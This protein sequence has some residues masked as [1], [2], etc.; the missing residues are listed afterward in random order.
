MLRA[1]LVPI[2]FVFVALRLTPGVAAEPQTAGRG[3]VSSILRT[4]AI[5][6]WDL[7][8]TRNF[9]IYTTAGS[10]AAAGLAADC[11]RLRTQLQEA[12]CDGARAAWNPKCD[13]V[14]HATVAEYVR[15]LGPGSEHSSGC[16]SLDKNSGRIVR[17][18]IDLR[19]DA[20]D[21]RTASLPHELTHVVVADQF[22]VQQ[23][24]RWADEGMAILAEPPSKRRRRYAALQTAL[25]RGHLLRPDEVLTLTA[26][27]GAGRIDA[28]YGESAL[29][30]AE[31][32]ARKSPAQF[33]RFVQRAMEVG[34]AR[35]LAE[36]YGIASVAQ[37]EPLWRSQ[38][39]SL[40]EPI[41]FFMSHPVDI[42]E[43]VRA[44]R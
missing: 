41:D 34:H 38:L 19:S 22:P 9:R 12:W 10:S 13:I 35:A 8:E 17:R 43:A 6:R 3:N 32:A 20:A 30:V 37:L 1:S 27:P 44:S 28:F 21:W 4:K 7:V 16:A 29:L 18:R 2:A 26:Y 23:I 5:G 24:P 31:L 40:D 15:Q 33:V 42:N 39:E 25:Q 36:C 11:E 14:V